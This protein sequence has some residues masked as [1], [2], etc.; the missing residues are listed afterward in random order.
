MKDRASTRTDEAP[1]H[2]FEMLRGLRGYT[3]LETVGCGYRLRDAGRL[4]YRRQ[5]PEAELGYTRR[6]SLAKG[7]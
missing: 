2:T 4:A 6:G 5:E 7:F 3:G 1:P